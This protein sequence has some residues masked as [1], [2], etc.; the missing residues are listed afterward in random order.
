MSM[1]RSLLHVAIL[2]VVVFLLRIAWS[3][4]FLQPGPK[5]PYCEGAGELRIMLTGPGGQPELAIQSC[6]T[7]DGSGLKDP[8]GVRF[9]RALPQIVLGLWHFV[10][11]GLLGGLAWAFTAVDCR[12][13]RGAGMLA[14]EATPPGEAAFRVQEDCVACDGRGRLGALDRWVLGMGW[15]QKP[16]LPPPAVRP[17]RGRAIS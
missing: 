12:L 7:C 1:G 14:I 13:C 10:F 16:P 4:D 17:R 15:E 3:F 6:A 9:K 2:L 5:C 8:Y 11:I